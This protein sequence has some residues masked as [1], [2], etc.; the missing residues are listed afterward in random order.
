MIF[1]S[2]QELSILALLAAVKREKGGAVKL[3]GKE[4]RTKK[5]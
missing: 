4:M 3:T 1:K 5:K 2:D